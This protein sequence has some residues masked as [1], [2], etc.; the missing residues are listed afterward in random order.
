M[1]GMRKALCVAAVSGFATLASAQCGLFEAAPGGPANAPVLLLQSVNAPDGAVLFAAGEF[2][3]IGGI[4]ATGLARW[5]GLAWHAE[6]ITDRVT[7]LGSFDAGSGPIPYCAT[8]SSSGIPTLHMKTGP[9]SWGWWAFAGQTAGEIHVIEQIDEPSGPA[10]YIGGSFTS[11]GSGVAARHAAKW[12][13]QGG[14]QAL[15]EGP[16]YPVRCFQAFDDGTGFKVFAGETDSE[17]TGCVEAWNGTNWRDIGPEYTSATWDL[18]VFD[19]GSGPQLFGARLN[20]QHPNFSYVARWDGSDWIFDSTAITGARPTSLCVFD[21][22]QGERLF[23][24]GGFTGRFLVRNAPGDWSIAAGG[25]AGKFAPFQFG[26]VMALE[27]CD[28]G[29]GATLWVAGEFLSAGGVSTPG[30]APLRG[31]IDPVPF[32]YCHGQTSAAGCAPTMGF[33]GAP[34][35]SGSFVVRATNADALRTGGF[36]Y[37][38]SGPRPPYHPNAQLCM[39]GP[40][41]RTGITNSGGTAQTCDGVLQLDVT[42]FVAT[43]P[44]AGGQPFAPGDLVWIQ[45]WERDP[46]ATTGGTIRYSDALRFTWLP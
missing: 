10:L 33:S 22:G 28:D 34:S 6:P 8:V 2:T 43:H 9:N 40:R 15:A 18:E 27:P 14:W 13:Q 46:S 5:D 11:L 41:Q 39:E 42:Q 19:D 21:D 23:V 24:G 44:N 35:L 29:Q 36:F 30:L 16:R 31:C 37:G 25:V 26:A 1:H 20:P 7:A 3:N 32:S 45:A 4:A 17:N 12:T 38:V